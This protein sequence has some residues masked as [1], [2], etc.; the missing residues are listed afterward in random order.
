MIK[1]FIIRNF[2]GDYTS[3]ASFNFLTMSLTWSSI[4]DELSTRKL[5][6]IND[7]YVWWKF[8]KF[9]SDF[10]CSIDD[11]LHPLKQAC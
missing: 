2:K 9:P 7:L 4:S 10:Q 3:V 5:A 11:L 6:K 8:K 1:E